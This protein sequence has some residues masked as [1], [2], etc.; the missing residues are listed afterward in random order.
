MTNI[1]Q[2]KKVSQDKGLTRQRS[3]ET[4]VSQDLGLTRQMS[5]KTK[6]SQGKG[7][8]TTVSQDIKYDADIANIVQRCME[9]FL[10]NFSKYVLKA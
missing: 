4:N 2:S 7:L 10:C 8:K 9:I 3:H 1:S 6:V 5:H